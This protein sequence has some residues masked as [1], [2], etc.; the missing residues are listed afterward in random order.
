MSIST[1]NFGEHT[2]LL[3]SRDMHLIRDRGW[4][5]RS[6]ADRMRVVRRDPSR[7]WSWFFLH[8]EI[9]GVFDSRRV[10]F[11]DGDWRNC[12]RSNL[13]LATRAEVDRSRHMVWFK[14]TY[15]H[16]DIQP[17]EVRG[18]KTPGE[19]IMRAALE[20]W[21]PFT[22]LEPETGKIVWANPGTKEF[23]GHAEK[24][25]LT[26]RLSVEAWELP[27]QEYAGGGFKH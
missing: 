12:S 24:L 20:T 25:Y 15:G 3:D 6:F 27:K 8:R 2:I 14:R 19:A 22:S 13:V 26:G 1:I 9:L 17:V 7:T 11:R 10:S 18:A 4:H 16:R 23:K 5:V 21:G